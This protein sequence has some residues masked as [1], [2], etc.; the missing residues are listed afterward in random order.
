MHVDDDPAMLDVSS[1]WAA[2]R[3][4]IDWLTASDPKTGLK[5]LSTHDVDCLVSDSFRTADGDPFVT[6]VAT[7]FPDLP[8]VLFTSTTY[9]ALDP[10]LRDSW[11]EYVRKGSTEP[12]DDLFDRVLAVTDGAADSSAVEPAPRATIR[13][14]GGS[15][16]DQWAS[17]GR[18]HPAEG[19]DL[20]TVIVTAVEAYTGRDAMEFPPLYE[21]IDADA[22]SS[23]IKHADGRMRDAVQVRFVYADCELAVT[24]DGVVLACD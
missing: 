12:F 10:A 7:T 4:E 1:D 11:M 20:S 21:A 3:N 14:D 16:A 6:R 19:D 17:I 2:T 9:D 23:L 8:V 18:Y 5:M 22:L 24:G 13:N 15:D